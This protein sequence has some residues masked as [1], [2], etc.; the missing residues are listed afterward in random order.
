MISILATSKKASNADV[1]QTFVNAGGWPNNGVSFCLGFLTPAF[2]LAGVDG[3]VHMSEE[4]HRAPVNIPRAMV[5]SVVI[6]GVAAFAYILTI[7]YAITDINSVLTIGA[8]T[9]FPIIG[10]FQLA[11]NNTRA[12]TAMLCGVIII[13]TMALFGIQASAARLTW[14]FARDQYVSL[15]L[16]CSYLWSRSGANRKPRYSGL[17][18]SSFLSHLTPSNKCPTRTTLLTWL[19]TSLLS[20][21]NIGSTTAFN[22]LLSLA[23]IGFYFSYGIPILMFFIRRFSTDRPIEFGPWTLGRLGYAINVLA[24][25]FCLFLIIFL[26]FPTVLPVTAQNMNYA[27]VVFIGVILFSLVDWIIRGHKRYTGPIREVRSETSSDLVQQTVT[28]EK[29]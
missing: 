9:G 27:S 19:C 5:W 23:T 16:D 29:L 6:N 8:N 10:V 3:V 22:A 18:F 7:L 14:A 13:S 12:A 21:I 25:A 24:M 1:W 11:T 20:L 2:A 17:P 4:T 26:P 15:F 28:D